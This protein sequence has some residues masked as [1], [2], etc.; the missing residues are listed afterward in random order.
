MVKNLPAIQQTWVPSLCQEDPLKEKMTIH[1]SILTWKIPWKEQFEGLYSMGSQR[2]GHDWA[3]NSLIRLDSITHAFAGF[4]TTKK[5]KKPM[6]FLVITLVLCSIA[7]SD[8][9]GQLTHVRAHTHTVLNINF[10]E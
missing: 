8:M 6:N 5:K 9:I 10:N 2:V 3:T 4:L 1:S 7:E